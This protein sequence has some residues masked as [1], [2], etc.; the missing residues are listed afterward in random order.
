MEEFES[1]CVPFQ[2]VLSTRAGTDCVR[3]FLRAATDADPQATILSVDGIGACDHVLRST[4]L[5]RLMRMPTAQAMLP[6]VRLSYGTPSRY[7]W[8]D[9]SGR[10]RFVTQAEG[11]EQEDPLMLLLL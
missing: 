8:V 9:A 5:E 1:E 2:Y 11:G 4:M 10:R 7:S 6:F 3:H